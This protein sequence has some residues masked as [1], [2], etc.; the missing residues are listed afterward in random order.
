M[1]ERLRNV[2]RDAISVTRARAFP[3]K[4]LQRFLRRGVAFTQLLGIIVLELVEVEFQAIEKADRL[5]ERFGRLTEQP[6]HFA[7]ALQMALRVGLQQASG[8]VDSDA[9]ANAGD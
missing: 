5:F 9:L 4:G 6:R 8:I 3:R 2:R 7:G 1:V